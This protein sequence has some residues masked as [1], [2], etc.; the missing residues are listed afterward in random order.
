MNRKDTTEFLRALLITDRLAGPGKYWASEVV[1]DYGT[2]HP[3]RVDFL[4][5]CP[6]GATYPSEI[7][8]GYFVSYEVKS[9]KEDV[10]S[11]SGLNFVAEKNYI[12]TTVKCYK[13][14]LP[15]MQSGKFYKHLKEMNEGNIAKKCD[16]LLAVPD[17]VQMKRFNPQEAVLDEMEKPTPLDNNGFWRLAKITNGGVSYRRRSTTE[18]LFCMVRS[19]K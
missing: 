13:E 19:G 12:V 16:F 18:L 3:K 9:C 4:Q 5:Y 2:T 10:Y 6:K 14:L 17:I 15:D 7:E 11:G 8:S 1:L